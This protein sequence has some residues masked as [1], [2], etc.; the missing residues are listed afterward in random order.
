MCPGRPVAHVNFGETHSDTRLIQPTLVSLHTLHTAFLTVAT[1]SCRGSLTNSYWMVE[2]LS[3][4][5]MPSCVRVPCW[6][7]KGV[8]CT[9]SYSFIR[10]SYTLVYWFPYIGTA[11]GVFLYLFPALLCLWLRH[12]ARSRLQ[13]AF[14]LERAV[15]WFPIR[16]QQGPT[17]ADR[18]LAPRTCLQLSYV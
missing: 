9:G 4:S 18:S 2:R 8:L 7:E 12:D 5:Y 10:L 17:G 11:C 16:E 13:A 14:Y 1:W 6:Q 3:G 15:L